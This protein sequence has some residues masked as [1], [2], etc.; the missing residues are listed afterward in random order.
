MPTVIAPES[1]IATGRRHTAALSLILGLSAC[2]GTPPADLAR[3]MTREAG[4]V[5]ASLFAPVGPETRPLRASPLPAAKPARP[6]PQGIAARNP[7]TGETMEIEMRRLGG[8]AAEIRQ[9]DGCVWRT[10]D[11]FAPAT[12]WRDCG[13]SRNWHTGRSEVTGGTG[14]WPLRLGAEGRFNRRATS[15]TGRRYEREATCRV[16]DAVEVLRDGHAPTPAF[17]VDCADGKRV[18]TTWWAPDQGPVAFRKTHDEHGIE[19]LWVAQ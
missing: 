10:D 18:R 4:L 15:H 7:R 9:S 16:T 17:V 3:S 14:L 12:A 11:W 6:L 2:G 1:L 13:D 8:G 19:E 5:A